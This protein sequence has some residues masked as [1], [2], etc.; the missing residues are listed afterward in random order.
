MVI[1]LVR[2]VVVVINV[3]VFIAVDPDAA[4]EA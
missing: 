1:N 2:V 3:F 4:G